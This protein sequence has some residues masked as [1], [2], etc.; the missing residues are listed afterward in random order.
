M[1][2]TYTVNTRQAT[3][4][5]HLRFSLQV[6]DYN[7]VTWSQAENGDPLLCVAGDA[8]HQIK[9]FNITTKQL[10]AVRHTYVQRNRSTDKAADPSRTRRC[11]L[12]SIPDQ[13]R[14]LTIQEHRR[15]CNIAHRPNHFGVR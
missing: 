4:A 8:S 14:S 9:V 10:V 2:V 7:S 1:Y 5:D 15:S 6:I 3:S 12:G 11:E 13:R